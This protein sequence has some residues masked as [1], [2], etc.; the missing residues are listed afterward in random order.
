MD[1]ILYWNDVA[2]EA[3]RVSHTNGKG[4]Q[5]GPTLSSRALAIVHLAMHD[6]WFKIEGGQDTYLPNLPAPGAGA[7]ATVAVAAAA[8]ATLQ[9]LFPSQQSYFD[10]KYLE[11]GLSGSG[12]D[13]GFTF[14]QLVAERILDDRK[15]DPTASDVGYVPP[16]GRGAHSPDPD[17]PKQGYHAP[18]YGAK[19]KGFAISDRHE[20]A[21]SPFNTPEYE[22]YV[23]EVVEKGIAPELMGTLPNN[24]DRRTP[25]ETLIGLYWAYD[26]AAGLGTP[27]RLYNQIVRK[28]ADKQGNDIAKNARL[29]ALINVAMADAGILAWDQK[30]IHN[31]WRPVVGIREHDESM[32]PAGM[33]PPPGTNA[34]DPLCDPGWLPLGAPSTNATSTPTMTDYPCGHVLHTMAKNVTP[35]FPAYPSGH[36]TFGAAAFQIT[37]L[38]YDANIGRNPDDLFDDLN[39]VSDELNGVNKDNAGTIRP[40][41]V[42]KFPRGLWDM[43]VENGLSRVY[44]G[45]HWRFD[46]FVNKP[47]GSLDLGSNIGGVPLG[48]TIAKDIFTNGMTKS[49][50][51]PRP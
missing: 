3:N 28:V 15:D 18:F 17:N 29:F 23:K 26:G 36:A 35:P 1:P 31:L 4:E 48:L 9:A 14:G 41:H 16:V 46:A 19:S 40:K 7:S 2:L 39:F 42:R 38:F 47:N 25:H 13:T 8:H 30:Y 50:V 24:A 33:V 11:A 37:R 6:A 20:L 10:R 49:T 45:V 5:T 22:G 34:F 51:P 12:L 21:D 43:I 44:L 32:G 27:P